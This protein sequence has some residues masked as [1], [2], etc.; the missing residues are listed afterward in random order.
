MHLSLNL[1][2]HFYIQLQVQHKV[3]P[4]FLYLLNHFVYSCPLTGAATCATLSVTQA[5][6]Q[7]QP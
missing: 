4:R 3:S 1:F 5:Q 6:P 2:V 7:I